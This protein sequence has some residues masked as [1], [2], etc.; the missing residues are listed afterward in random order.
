MVKAKVEKS[1]SQEVKKSKQQDNT[2]PGGAHPRIGGE[3]R[4]ADDT[5]AGVRDA[6]GGVWSLV[7]PTGLR[8]RGPMPPETSG[9]RLLCFPPY[10]VG[11]NR[12]DI[13]SRFLDTLTYDPYPFQEEALLAWFE[14]EGGVLVSA[15]TGMGKTLIAEAA[16]YEALV[17][18]QRLYYTTPLIALTDQKFREFQDKA[19]VWGFRR[20]D[21]GLITGNRRV[22]PD[23]RVRVVV[24]EIL[25]NHLL[26]SEER[27]EDVSGVVMDEFHYFNDMERGIVWDNLDWA[28]YPLAASAHRASAA[29][30]GLAATR[31]FSAF[32]TPNIYGTTYYAETNGQSYLFG[33][34]FA[35]GSYTGS[36]AGSTAEL[37]G[38]VESG[39]AFNVALG[40]Y[41]GDWDSQDNFLRAQIA[42]G[43]GLM[44]VWSGLPSWWLHPLGLGETTGAC[45]R[46]SVGNGAGLYAPR[47]DGWEPAVG[48]GHLALMGDPALRLRYV[49]VPSGFTARASG[50]SATFSWTAPADGADGYY[51]YELDPD[52]DELVRL[53]P[54]RITATSYSSATL[55]LVAGRTYA[56]RAA[57][58]EDGASGTYWNLGLAALATAATSTSPGSDA[59]VGVADAGVSRTDAGASGGTD[60]GA[61]G[62]TDAG[63]VLVDA[64]AVLVD[65]G[66]ATSDGGLVVRA[67][68]GSAAGDAG[69]TRGDGGVAAPP[70]ALAG[71]MGC[72][73]ASGVR[74]PGG[75]WAL[76]LLG[77][78]ALLARRVRSRCVA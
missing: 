9:F 51:L 68:A 31:R 74:G 52:T 11:M 64:G 56:V 53:V 73:I 5:G 6:A 43:A 62:G 60:A 45:M 75:A 28:G 44:S 34:H 37:A 63:A 54:E 48:R 38:S 15:P 16:I 8:V 49:G 65:A 50:P 76:G 12:S 4:G 78:L 41:F 59:G 21:I 22:N 20:D 18:G 24:A 72:S 57:R 26:S 47:T 58:L 10:D 71:Y 32:T 70:A 36:G 39:V 40:S 67:D 1:K 33:G 77:V 3:P 2:G 25:L 7:G 55:A 46:I 13:W 61:S 42:R 23:A 69:V 17:S 66:A 14:A 29:L 27:F 35:G 19:E 30:V